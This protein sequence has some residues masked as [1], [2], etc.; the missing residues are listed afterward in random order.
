MVK[1]HD[2]CLQMVPGLRW[3]WWWLFGTDLRTRRPPGS[4]SYSSF[5]LPGCETEAIE[6]IDVAY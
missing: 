6:G 5:L 2:S 3:L 4:S 1:K